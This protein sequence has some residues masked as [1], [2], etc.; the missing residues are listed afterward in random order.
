MREGKQR[1]SPA[2]DPGASGVTVTWRHLHSSQTFTVTNPLRVIAHCDIDAAYSQFEIVRLGLDPSLPVA[3]QQWQGLIAINYPARKFG[4][5]R[6]ETPIEAKKKCPHL[7]LVHVAT[8]MDSQPVSGYY[9]NPRPETHK[10]SLDPY[11]RESQKILKIFGDLCP[12]IEKASIDEAFLD[13]T[14]PVRQLM[15]ERYPILAQP[16]DN[17][18]EPLPPPPTTLPWSE[19]GNLIP[20]DPDAPPETDDEPIT[21]QDVALALGA[22]MMEK[23][24]KEVYTQLGYTCSAGIAK[25]KMLSKL[26]SAWKKPNAQTV[27]RDTAVHNFLKPLKFQKIRFLGGKLGDSLANEYESSTVGDLWSVSLQELQRKLGNESGMWCWEII[28][29]ID[30]TEVQPKAATKSML[31]SKNFKPAINKWADGAYWLR[32]SATELAARLNEQRESVPGI[33]PKTITLNFR[34]INYV[35]RSKQCAF[36]Y[37]NNLSADYVFKI[38]ERL[39]KEFQNE[40]SK[41]DDGSMTPATSLGLAF[42]GLERVASGQAGIQDFFKSAESGSASLRAQSVPRD[43]TSPQPIIIDVDD[44]QQEEKASYTCSRCHRILKAAVPSVETA[45]EL[46]TLEQRRAAVEQQLAR[47]HADYHYARDLARKENDASQRAAKRKR[48]DTQSKPLAEQTKSVKPRNGGQASLATYFAA[49]RDRK[50]TPL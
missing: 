13:F 47:E 27:L 39:L 6:H 33:W 46:T 11:R 25:N 14:A 17:L 50:R 26:C 42:N 16:P 45:D 36:P 12:L 28:R 4:I 37:S 40:G 43:Q 2:P 1:A 5:T 49:P 29:G 9:D 19:L 35:S 31:S 23:C 8:Y 48:Q 18:D 34:D 20:V 21:W 32:V 41:P 38:T 22:E 44:D 3:V 24:R 30:L 10:V 15:L 7:I